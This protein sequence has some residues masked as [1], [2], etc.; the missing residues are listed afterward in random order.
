[1]DPMFKHSPLGKTQTSVQKIIQ[2]HKQRTGYREQS[3]K[4]NAESRE[5]HIGKFNTDVEDSNEYALFGFCSFW[6]NIL[7]D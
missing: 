7:G 3:R 5:N 2:S 1:M 6:F 4:Q